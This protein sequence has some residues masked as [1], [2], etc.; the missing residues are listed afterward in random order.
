MSSISEKH[1]FLIIR[2]ADQGKL[3]LQWYW[4]FVSVVIANILSSDRLALTHLVAI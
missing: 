2:E 3:V 4:D 1:Q